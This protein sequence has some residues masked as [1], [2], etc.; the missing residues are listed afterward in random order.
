MSLHLGSIRGTTIDVDPSFFF[1]VGFFVLTNYDPQQ[2]R[3][4]L[5]WIPVVFI[6]ILVHELAHAA[7]N[8][9]FGFGPSRVL[10]GG[11]GGVTINE[12][13]ARPWQDMLIAFAGPAA[14]FLLWW[15]CL[16][17]AMKV[18]AVQHD[19]MLVALMPLMIWAN[20]AWGIFNL[21]PISPLDGGHVL[22]NFLRIILPE[23]PA[24]LISVWSG[25]ILGGLLA[26]WWFSHMMFF[27]GVL[28]AWFVRMNFA[29]WQIYRAYQRPGD[30]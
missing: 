24:F 18:P 5:L 21:L 19:P 1:L 12:R 26:L 8:G 11:M 25:M 14:S 13:R 7:A 2:P 28:M 9:T 6:S 30:E 20:L 10:L 3:N 16:Q 29:Q 15:G 22:R 23:K 4:A 17:L 27:A